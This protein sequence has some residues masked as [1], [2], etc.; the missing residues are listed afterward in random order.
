M[1]VTRYRRIA[2]QAPLVG[3]V[4][5]M[6]AFGFLTLTGN[7]DWRSY[8]TFADVVRWLLGYGAAGGVVALVA[9]LGGGT[10]VA[11]VDYRLQRAAIARVSW[12]GV[13][14]GVAILIATTALGL[15]SGESGWF[16]LYAVVGIVLGLVAAIAAATMVN[17]AE[18][19]TARTGGRSGDVANAV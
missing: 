5:G 13:G 3:A 16:G 10:A 6:A 14:A 9:L 7:P 4:G 1:F 17:R 15:V 19:A 2:L 12:A 8:L 18:R 11:L